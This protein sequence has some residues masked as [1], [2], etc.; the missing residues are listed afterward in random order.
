M[1]VTDVEF[2]V[3][4]VSERQFPRERLPEVVLAGRSNVG[5]SSLLNRLTGCRKLARTSS[6]PGKTQS[7]NFYRVRGLF[8]LVDL[9]G[10]GYARVS[11]STRSR[12]KDLIESYFRGK[13][14]IVLVLQLV[15]ARLGPTALDLHLA[16]WLKHLSVPFMV[17][18]TKS[19]K[20]SRSG[21]AVQLSLIRE[22]ID[23]A[24]VLLTSAT[25]G[26]GCREIWQRVEEATRL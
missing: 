15:D 8:F 7:V 16:N 18:A 2:V 22:T 3:S 11:R 1:K 20:L 5:K 19:D 25:T 6:T 21:Q 9:P 26:A 23:G 17:I 12:W 10:Y 24:A 14:E 13:R 4:A